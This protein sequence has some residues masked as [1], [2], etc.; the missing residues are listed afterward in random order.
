MLRRKFRLCTAALAG[1][2]LIAVLA[3]PV[4]AQPAPA[5][6]ASWLLHELAT[7]A[8]VLSQK[9]TAAKQ[10]DHA[11]TWQAW[12]GLYE[13]IA[14]NPAAD[15]LTARAFCESNVGGNNQLAAEA[16]RFG[17]RDA[18]ALY[19]A[20]ARMWADL[21]HQ[22]AAGGALTIAFPREMQ[23][24]I[25]GLADTPWASEGPDPKIRRLVLCSGLASRVRSCQTQLQEMRHE[26]GMGHDNGDAIVV[27]MTICDRDQEAYVASC[28]R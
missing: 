22:L 10:A 27:E 11:R 20:S 4:V 2:A 15:K 8:R 14:N 18:A 24:P 28:A 6:T 21:D 25:P 7:Q 16:D 9:A 19:R 3:L 5:R 17:A 23:H 13:Q 1:A 26:Q 12:A